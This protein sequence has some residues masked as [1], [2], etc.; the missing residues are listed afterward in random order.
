MRVSPKVRL[1][2]LA[3]DP[4]LSDFGP[5]IDQYALRDFISRD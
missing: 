4:K 1:Q 5:Y 2:I 3:P